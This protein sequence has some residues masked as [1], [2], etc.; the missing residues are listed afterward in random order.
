ME[1][2]WQQGRGDEIFDTFD[3]L[4]TTDYTHIDM[5]HHTTQTNIQKRPNRLSPS[6][7]SLHTRSKKFESYKFIKIKII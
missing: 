6:L 7:H 4:Y 2:A 5:I 3:T 1:C